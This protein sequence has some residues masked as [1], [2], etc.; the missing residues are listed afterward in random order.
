MCLHD[1][2]RAPRDVKAYLRMGDFE[3][4]PLAKAS[5]LQR[6]VHVAA[7]TPCHEV[8]VYLDFYIV[9]VY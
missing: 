8:I 3:Q 6:L 1:T 7:S 2:L 5:R 9:C 4:R